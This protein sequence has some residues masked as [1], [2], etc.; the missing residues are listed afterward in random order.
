VVLVLST[1]SSA[2]P[3]RFGTGSSDLDAWCLIPFETSLTTHWAA[4]SRPP[5]QM[6]L[7]Y[8]H[9]GLAAHYRRAPRLTTA[10]AGRDLSS[11]STDRVYF[12]GGVEYAH[13]VGDGRWA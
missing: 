13:R 5:M 1:W 11:L 7:G 9:A 4:A 2:A 3:T 12:D 8:R 10:G 6:R